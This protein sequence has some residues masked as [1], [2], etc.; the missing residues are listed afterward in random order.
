MTFNTPT[1]QRL[2]AV[3]LPILLLALAWFLLVSPVRSL[4]ADNQQ[5][6][7]TLQQQLSRYQQVNASLA[8][9]E[10]QLAQQTDTLTESGLLL[11]GRTDALRS[12]QLQQH[13][14]ALIADVNGEL[15]QVQT[16][17][18]GQHGP[19]NIVR[20]KASLKLS[21]PQLIDCL[22]QLQTGRPLLTVDDIQIR[23]RPLQTLRGRGNTVVWPLTV[24]LQLT[25]Y[26]QQE[27]TL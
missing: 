20:V 23:A 19:L 3:S 9:L 25:G 17:E 7:E 27:A 10:Q 8:T 16:L 22:E 26:S 12:A 14:S 21:L 6:I 15:E 24:S 4:S 13:L 1:N 5:Q 2:L 18:P 11:T